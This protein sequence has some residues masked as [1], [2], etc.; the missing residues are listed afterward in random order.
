MK[1]L[2]VW[3]DGQ[4]PGK[5][6]LWGPDDVARLF[7]TPNVPETDRFRQLKWD[8]DDADDAGDAVFDAFLLNEEEEKKR[9]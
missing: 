2:R 3:K 1:P 9:K 8:A 4:D 6:T 5:A 7:Q